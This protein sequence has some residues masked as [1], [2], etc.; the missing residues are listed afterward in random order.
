MVCFRVS[1]RGAAS[2]AK[3]LIAFSLCSHSRVFFFSTPF[4]KFE[5]R[6]FVSEWAYPL[7]EV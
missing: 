3:R 1:N 4:L 2:D 6:L 5:I 7:P